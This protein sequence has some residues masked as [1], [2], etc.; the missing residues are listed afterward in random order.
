MTFPT[1]R[2]DNKIPSYE[3]AAIIATSAG[4][5]AEFTAHLKANN[6]VKVSPHRPFLGF[7]KWRSAYPEIS[8]YSA[9]L[10]NRRNSTPGIVVSSTCKPN[11]SFAAGLKIASI[12]NLSGVAGHPPSNE[13][14]AN[15]SSNSS[16]TQCQ[17]QGFA[18]TASSTT[19][20]FWDWIKQYPQISIKIC[21]EV[22][23][24]A[25]VTEW[26]DFERECIEQSGI[27]PTMFALNTQHITNNDA[28][29]AHWDT[30]EFEPFSV[31]TALNTPISRAYESSDGLTWNRQQLLFGGAIYA[32]V[33]SFSAL[34]VVP[35]HAGFFNPKSTQ[36]RQSINIFF[37]KSHSFGGN[38]NV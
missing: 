19:I 20:S 34:A 32:F 5:G 38:A 37:G 24:T 33:S 22:L 36:S 31:Q 4:Y 1:P 2:I 35:Q 21:F 8:S 23:Q 3:T 13:Y 18:N 28:V 26:A 6:L 17:G 29:Q 11:V 7:D 30:D 16:T 12:F 15:F 27:S 14:H 9:Y 10:N 25:P